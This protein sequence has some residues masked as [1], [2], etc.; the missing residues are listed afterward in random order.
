VGSL[1]QAE[2]VFDLFGISDSPPDFVVEFA[3]AA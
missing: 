2:Q 1:S 3:I